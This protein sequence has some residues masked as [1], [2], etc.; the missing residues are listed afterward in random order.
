[1]VLTPKEQYELY[2]RHKPLVTKYL[3]GVS[4]GKY[5][6][7]LAVGFAGFGRRHSDACVSYGGSHSSVPWHKDIRELRMP[8]A[9]GGRTIV[10][11]SGDTQ[12]VSASRVSGGGGWP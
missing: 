7:D 3:V 4:S 6:L 2:C 1:M 11:W 9:F 5:L 8:Y 10:F 12:V